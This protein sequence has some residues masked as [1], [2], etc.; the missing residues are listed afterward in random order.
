[1]HPG[2][3]PIPEPVRSAIRAVCSA[4]SIVTVERDVFYRDTLLGHVVGRGCDQ[5]SAEDD[6]AAQER[7]MLLARSH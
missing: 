6:A 2:Q 1:M 3:R 5:P 7:A 4:A